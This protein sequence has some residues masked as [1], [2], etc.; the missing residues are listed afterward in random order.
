M[1]SRAKCQIMT[2]KNNI[3]IFEFM[4][5]QKNP[6]HYF[7][8]ARAC[9]MLLNVQDSR[10]IPRHSTCYSTTGDSRLD[11]RWCCSVRGVDFSLTALIAF[12]FLAFACYQVRAEEDRQSAFNAIT[13]PCPKPAHPPQIHHLSLSRF[14][15][16]FNTVSHNIFYS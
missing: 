7:Y 12:N 11:I 16:R 4:L 6:A 14:G 9:S 15:L 13:Q 10:L 3:I 5:T 8:L 2:G 1:L